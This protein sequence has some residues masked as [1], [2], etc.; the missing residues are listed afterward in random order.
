MEALKL[1]TNHT[2]KISFKNNQSLKYEIYLVD[3]IDYCT[4]SCTSKSRNQCPCRNYFRITKGSR[5]SKGDA[6]RVQRRG[7][8]N[9]QQELSI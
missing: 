5:H 3:V 9:Q 4:I 8:R 6:S 1:N 2:D 7:Q